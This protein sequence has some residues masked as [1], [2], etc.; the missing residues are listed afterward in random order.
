M[1]PSATSTAAD[2]LT[3]HAMNHPGLV[4]G[5]STNALGSMRRSDD[6]RLL[7]VPRRAFAAAM[8]ADPERLTV[9]GAVHGVDIARVDEPAGAVLGVDG[10]VTDRPGL[11]LLATFGDCRPLVLFDPVRRALAL[12]HAGWR[13]TAAG[14]ATAAVRKLEREYGCRPHDLLVGIGPGICGDCYEVGPEVASR[15]PAS[16]SRPGE[17]D[18]LLLDL[19]AVD[20]LQLIEVGVDA[21]RI[22]VHPAC[23][24]ESPELPSHRGRPDGSRFACLAF[25][26]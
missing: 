19:V 21:D 13:G 20:R 9:V 23:T 5:F 8:G 2:V 26:T 24:L 7:T 14:M 1:D 6:G 4:H 17:G 16:C 18:R 11:P 3:L 12:C 25:L 22:S 10:L 15:F